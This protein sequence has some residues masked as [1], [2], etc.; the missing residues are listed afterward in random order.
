MASTSAGSDAVECSVVEVAHP[1]FILKNAIIASW[2]QK[3]RCSLLN[4]LFHDP[5]AHLRRNAK[6]RGAAAMTITSWLAVCKGIERG[7]RLD[8]KDAFVLKEKPVV[9]LERARGLLVANNIFLIV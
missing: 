1:F 6:P 2:K 3:M 4:I 8:L 5:T 9:G 7:V